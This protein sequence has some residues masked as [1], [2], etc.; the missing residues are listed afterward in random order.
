M[1]E[2]EASWENDRFGSTQFE[3]PNEPQAPSAEAMQMTRDAVN[4]VLD[5]VAKS[6]TPRAAL[7]KLA[8]VRSMF[9]SGETSLELAK[10]YGVT[11][12]EIQRVRKN[13]RAEFL[14]RSERSL[15]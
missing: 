13:L 14:G 2:T 3:Y 4:F 12:R 10:R 9:G 11:P 7:L 15:R 6:R 8:C 1:T 5:I